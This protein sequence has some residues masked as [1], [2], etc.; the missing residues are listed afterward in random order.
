[1]KSGV[2][3]PNGLESRIDD[4]TCSTKTDPD[5][6]HEGETRV[7]SRRRT[8]KVDTILGTTLDTISVSRH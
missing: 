1:M 7:D 5:Q 3:T 2:I 8:T 4:P 6:T